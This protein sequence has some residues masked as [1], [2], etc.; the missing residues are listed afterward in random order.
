MT[1]QH[2]WTWPV[3]LTLCISLLAL[4]V[5]GASLTWQIV[6][7]RRSCPR[8]SVKTVSGIGG[9]PGVRFV[10]V[11]ATNSGRLG[12]EIE[13][14]GFQLPNGR[15][16]QAIHD[17]LGQPVELPMPLAPGRTAT[18]LYAAQHIWEIL[19]QEGV[20]GE[21]VRPYVAANWRP[22]STGHG[23]F[24]G[25]AIHLGQRIANIHS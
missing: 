16:I 21:N 13:Q 18:M 11:E 7:W 14:F 2:I 3:I 8:V 1:P 9:R 23:R 4:A 15:H 17:Y 10:G 20:S 5:S 24:D 12:T 22:V 25:D 19:R 6:S